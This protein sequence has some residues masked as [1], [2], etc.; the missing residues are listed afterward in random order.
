M[1]LALTLDDAPTI[2]EPGIPP[3]PSIMDKIR[4]RLERAH[5]AHCV[6]FVVGERAMGHE[7]SL[8]RWMDAGYQLGNHTHFHGPAHEVGVAQTIESIGLCDQLLERIGAFERGPKWF[9]FPHLSRGKDS[10]ARGAIQEAYTKLGYQL[11]SASVNFDDDRFERAWLAARDDDLREQIL[12]RYE[13]SVVQAVR[14]ADRRFRDLVASTIPPGQIGYAHFSSIS[15]AALPRLIESLRGAGCCL[16]ALEEV[17]FEE[18]FN[19]YVSDLSLDGL[20][21]D[22]LGKKTIFEKV[23]RRIVPVTRRFDFFEQAKKGPLWPYLN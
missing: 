3:L 14:Q 11:A 1:K 16:V 6:A 10:E 17:A 9:R 5:V 19:S 18:P 2:V 23:M 7:D 8:R 13:R 22:A 20:V 21:S 15:C 4:E 12:A